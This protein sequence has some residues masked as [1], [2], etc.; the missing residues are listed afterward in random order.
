MSIRW[1]CRPTG[2]YWW[3]AT[4]PRWAARAAQYLGRLNT[5]GTLDTSFNPGADGYVDSL[6]VQA[7]GKILVGG[8]FTTLGGQSAQYLGRL[9]AD[10]TLDTGF[11]PGASYVVYSLAVQAD[12]KIVVGGYFTTLGGQSA[13]VSAGS[14]PTARWTPASIPERTVMSLRWRCRRTGRYWW[15][16]PLPRWVARAARILAGSMPTARW[17]PPSIPERTVM[18]YSL[19]VQA[20]GKILVGGA[21][22][23]LG[24]QSRS[25]L[26]RLTPTE[27]ATQSLAFDGSTIIWQRG[28]SSPEVWRTV[29]D[30]ST[31][32]SNW[33]S[34][35]AGTRVAGDWQLTGLAWPTNAS[36]RARGFVTGGYDNG[37]G[38]FVE[39]VTGP[40]VIAVQ[41]ASQLVA[42]GTDVTLSITA[43]G[44]VPLS[45]QWNFNGTNL[46]GATNT[47]L[48]LTNVQFSQAGNY[49][50][51]VTNLHGSIVSSNATLTVIAPPVI[52]N[53]TAES[54]GNAR[55]QCHVQRRSRRHTAVQLPVA[56]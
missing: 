11:N 12:G 23:T 32:G 22:A 21:F 52:L 56:L 36:L 6:A 50:V 37:S 2:R 8:D 43:Q 25:C 14:T 35:G 45:Y 28:G 41:P 53:A 46:D 40:P 18:S 49:T 15:A 20:D 5:D 38:W 34:L 54:D 29:F 13:C 17:I 1:R 9:N 10:G 55:F 3:V 30:G 31:N 51:L 16:A 33:I 19:A 7:D 24:G 48:T 27:P 4:L 42:V 26:G 47:L 44:S 39:T